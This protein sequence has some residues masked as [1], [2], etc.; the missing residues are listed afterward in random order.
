MAQ[1]IYALKKDVYKNKP[2]E[3]AGGLT[4]NVSSRHSRQMWKE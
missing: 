4:L 2:V 3:F 1:S